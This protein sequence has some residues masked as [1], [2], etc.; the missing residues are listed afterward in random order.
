MLSIAV[1][2]EG[3][4]Q[5]LAFLSEDMESDSTSP[6]VKI[7]L[8]AE[9]PLIK[10]ATAVFQVPWP[11]QR[12]NFVTWKIS[13][14]VAKIHLGQL[15]CFSLG[16]LDAK[17]DWGRAKDYVEVSYGWAVGADENSPP[18]THTHTSLF[19]LWGMFS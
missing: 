16:N 5:E 17:R 8:S 7:S 1:S 18:N 13:R 4:E 11:T 2:E 15:E 9:L 3:G 14:L 19:V 10:R 12:A 6:A